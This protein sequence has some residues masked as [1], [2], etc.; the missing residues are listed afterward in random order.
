M[1]VIQPLK[2]PAKK[3]ID[4]YEQVRKG[5]QLII[6]V[7]TFWLF[8]IRVVFQIIIE[9]IELRELGTVRTMLRQTDPMNLLKQSDIQ[10]LFRVHSLNPH[11]VS[12]YPTVVAWLCRIF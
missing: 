7:F 10:R 9:L 12:T 8:T 2:L 1:K 4:L 11:W 6:A 5:V 3:L